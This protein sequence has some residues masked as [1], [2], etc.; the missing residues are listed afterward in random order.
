L[1]GLRGK[2]GTKVRMMLQR[3]DNEVAEFERARPGCTRCAPVQQRMLRTPLAA[4]SS[5]GAAFR[6]PAMQSALGARPFNLGGKAAFDTLMRAPA[7]FAGPCAQKQAEEMREM[8]EA[9]FRS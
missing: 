1:R 8:L 5:S 9:S 4:L 6:G 7:G 2:S 3:V